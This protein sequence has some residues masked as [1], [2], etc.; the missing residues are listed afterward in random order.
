MHI[1]IALCTLANWDSLVASFL[2]LKDQLLIKRYRS[3]EA[4]RNAGPRV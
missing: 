2:K 3:L 4:R 1:I